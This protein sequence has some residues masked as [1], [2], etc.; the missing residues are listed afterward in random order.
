MMDIIAVGR[1]PYGTRS[2]KDGTPLRV[3]DQDGRVLVAL[4]RAKLA[5]AKGPG[6]HVESKA[7]AAE[8]HDTDEAH[9][10][11][12]PRTKRAYKRRDMSAE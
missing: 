9:E 6:P 3:T 8:D 11:G 2:L 1:L 5:P 4:G 12:K 10:D 7:M